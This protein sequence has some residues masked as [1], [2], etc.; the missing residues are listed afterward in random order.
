MI[1]TCEISKSARMNQRCHDSWHERIQ[2][3]AEDTSPKAGVIYDWL[4]TPNDHPDQE[5][6]AEDT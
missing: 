6:C 1:V 5:R 2:R 4:I 3:F